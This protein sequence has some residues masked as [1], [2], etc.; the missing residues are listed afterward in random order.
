[1]AQV[2]EVAVDVAAIM[3]DF[4]NV[5]VKEE[6][7]FKGFEGYQYK[8]SA[9]KTLID[10]NGGLTLG[11]ARDLA[12]SFYYDE[13][14]KLLEEIGVKMLS[15]SPVYDAVIP[16]GVD[17][18][19]LGGG[20]PELFAVEIEANQAMRESIRAF[21]I[22]GGSIYAECGGLMYLT[23]EL[24]Y[25]EQSYKM[26]GILGG[27]SHMTKSLQNFGHVEATYQDA[28]TKDELITIRGHEFHHSFVKMG[29]ETPRLIKVAGKTGERQCGYLKG[30]VL[31]TY[32]HT[33]F[34]SNLDFVDYL[35]HFFLR[36]KI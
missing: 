25:N 2:V 23:N 3:K 14:L 10:S 17:A 24:I 22:N 30:N 28:I 18:I 29:Q 21:A 13:N 36:G 31:A 12:F 1:M 15:F 6:A 26:T 35:I 4:S 27:S 8:I 20:Y 34:Y 33:H 9:L 5:A 16:E 19:L 11:V 7:V 32:V